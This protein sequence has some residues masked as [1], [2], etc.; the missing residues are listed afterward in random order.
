MKVVSFYNFDK[1]LDKNEDDAGTKT[2]KIKEQS[3]I[4]SKCEKIPKI[5]STN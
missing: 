4:I 3:I 5:C 1:N 2:S